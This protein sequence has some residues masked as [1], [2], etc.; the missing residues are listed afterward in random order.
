MQAREK[1]LRS[2][3]DPTG[4]R[5]IP[6]TQPFCGTENDYGPHGSAAAKGISP[7]GIWQRRIAKDENLLSNTKTEGE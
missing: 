5:Q 2:L 7:T 4:L 1:G 6:T 3:S